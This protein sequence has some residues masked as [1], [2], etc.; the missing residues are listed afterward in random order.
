VAV[1]NDSKVI[2]QM[3]CSG[4]HEPGTMPLNVLPFLSYGN[5]A[6]GQTVATS[7]TENTF[8]NTIRIEIQASSKLHW[9][10][11]IAVSS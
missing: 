11:Y 7:T 4:P 6:N 3:A 9:A 10:V 2:I 5:C 8:G 1:G